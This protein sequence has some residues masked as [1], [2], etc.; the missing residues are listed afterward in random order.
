MKKGPILKTGECII[1]SA[2]L[3]DYPCRLAHITENL[4]PGAKGV[5]KKFLTGTMPMFVSF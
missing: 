5:P 2:R 3:V 1:Q 4:S